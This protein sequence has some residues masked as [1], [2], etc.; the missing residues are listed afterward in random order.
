MTLEDQ[1]DQ[2]FHQ[3]SDRLAETRENPVTGGRW[4]SG[5]DPIRTQKTAACRALRAGAWFESQRPFDAPALPLSYGDRESLKGSSLGYIVALFARSIAVRGFNTEG[6][7]S[8]DEYARGVVASPF[9]PDIVRL[10]EGLRLRFPPKQ[11]P[12]LGSGLIWKGPK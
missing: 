5:V 2:L 4:V 12:G 8:F 9:A 3:A 11:L 10:D 6:H 1:V 7:P